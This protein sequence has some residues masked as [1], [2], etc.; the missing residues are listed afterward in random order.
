MA[1]GSASVNVSAEVEK[2]GFKTT[3]GAGIVDEKPGRT[4]LVGVLVKPIGKHS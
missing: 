2:T 4:G 3:R 1:G